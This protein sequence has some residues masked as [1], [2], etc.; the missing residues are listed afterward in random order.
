MM[1]D[2]QAASQSRAVAL[3]AQDLE[4]GYNDAPIIR[5][6]DLEIPAGEFTI[7]VGPNACGKS[8]LLRALARV[9]PAKGTITIA[10]K[11]LAEFR[12]K[13]LAQV[14]GLLPQSPLAPDGIRV[15]DLIAR[16]RYPH[17]D[18]F[19]RWQEKDHQAVAAAMEKTRVTDLADKRLDELSGGQRQRVWL[20]MIL[21][22]ET[23]I[24]LFDEPTTYLDITHQV[25]VLNVAREL[26]QAGVT[27]VMV[28]HELTLAFRYA[29]Y[30][31]VMAQGA[32]AARG[33]VNEIVTESL[34][35]EVYNLDCRLLEDPET[36]RPIV[37]PRATTL[38]ASRAQ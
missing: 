8:T 5:E 3:R 18:I 34:L 33:S 20:A 29:T 17:Q 36:G 12:N 21:A 11:Q 15:Y 37:I 38:P 9:L 23:Q 19:G 1:V 24:V 31:V 28:L 2:K 14:M 16:G 4:V 22:Q 13:E 27:V 32:I 10:G 7:I 25:E 35:R 26:Q 30:L 6:L